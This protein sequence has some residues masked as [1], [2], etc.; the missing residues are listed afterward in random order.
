MSDLFVF[1]FDI[2]SSGCSDHSPQIW[3]NLAIWNSCFKKKPLKFLAGPL[4][5]SVIPFDAWLLPCYWPERGREREIATDRGEKKQRMIGGNRE[6]MA[7]VFGF[8]SSPSGKG[9]AESGL[10]PPAQSQ[11]SEG[12]TVHCVIVNRQCISLSP[13]LPH[14]TSQ[15]H[16]LQMTPS[17]T[18]T[19][20][21][22][23]Q[24]ESKTQLV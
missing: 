5:C 11:P 2:W 12:T 20:S 14:Q 21:S 1:L 19:W 4:H 22:P 17:F 8:Q 23:V 24:A 15:H 6:G 3:Q 18:F 10:C 7:A 9:C 13:L 16:P